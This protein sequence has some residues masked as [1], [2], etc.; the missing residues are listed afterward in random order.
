MFLEVAHGLIRRGGQ[1][2][3]LVPSGI[4][5]DKGST[6]L[7]T[8]FL[9]R[10]R[11]R[12]LFGFENRNKIFDIDTRFK[13]GP[14]IVEKA[15]TTD[16]I[17]TAFMHRDLVDWEHAERHVIPY[18]KTQLER[19]SPKTRAILEIRHRR[20]LEILEKI[21]ANSVLLGDDSE[22][23]WKIQYAREFDM[24]NDSHLFAPRP[25]WEA[26][27]YKPDPYGRWIGPDGD[28]AIPL[29]Q[30]RLIGQFDFSRK[31]WVSGKGRG[32]V[33]RTLAWENKTP[34]P[35]FLGSLGVLAT[36]QSYIPDLKICYM[37]MSSATNERSM[38]ATLIRT[39]PA[40]SNVIALQAEQPAALFALT[41]TLNSFTFDALLRMRFVG[42]ALDYHVTQQVPVPKW[43]R[44]GA[45]EAAIRDV[46][47]RLNACHPIFA[48]EWLK[49]ASPGVRSTPWKA[50]WALTD[51]ERLRLR[52][53][54]DAVIAKLYGV[55][56]IALAWILRDCDLGTQLLATARLAG[57]LDPKGFWRVDRDKDP[58][59]RQTVLSLAA[60]RDLENTI[61][62]HGDDPVRGIRAFC[63]ASDGEGW[64]LPSTIR[65]GD[66][67][68]GRDDRAKQLQ[69]VRSRLGERFYPWQL[70]QSV[71][72]SWAEC[73]MHART[74]LGD[75]DFTRLKLELAQASAVY[76]TEPG[77]L[78]AAETAAAYDSDHD[79]KAGFD[80]QPALFDDTG[81]PGGK[82]K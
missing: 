64:Q 20:D 9:T 57:G 13:F 14:V 24:T 43:T 15:G 36:S 56:L 58:E 2:G 37:R 70:R 80:R 66:Y 33:W 63:G 65:L 48:P 7:R 25:Q 32:S 51:Y 27:G 1:M 61:T 59:L 55:D 47:L 75:D 26:K 28:V 10:C 17:E 8:L 44:L 52:C 34:E 81:A 82:R 42:L 71:A 11:W 16:A 49:W 5:T 62:D 6:D 19:F 76:E 78:R 35:E 23:G 67:G 60:F 39:F 31:G 73:E 54:L 46:V 4:Y 38:I 18:P 53:V 68:L 40:E 30:G 29:Y 50:S 72:E 12:W 45:V 74:V 69:P 22:D 79:R 77:L 21:Y 3:L 41:A